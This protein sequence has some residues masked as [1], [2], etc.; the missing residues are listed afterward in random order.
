MI[1]RFSP[2]AWLWCGLFWTF[3]A[4]YS[5]AH[6]R[7]LCAELSAWRSGRQTENLLGLWNREWITNTAEV[8]LVEVLYDETLSGIM[9][10][11]KTYALPPL[12]KTKLQHYRDQFDFRNNRE[13]IL[14]SEK[15]SSLEAFASHQALLLKVRFLLDILCSNIKHM[16]WDNSSLRLWHMT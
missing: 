2:P 7:G 3:L 15:K 4:I 6:A 8:L 14:K 5:T 1:L 13:R 10:E 11:W 9:N 16:Y 12:R